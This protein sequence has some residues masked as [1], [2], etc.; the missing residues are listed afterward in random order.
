MFLRRLVIAPFI[1]VLLI[2]PP[3]A[4]AATL[5]SSWLHQPAHHPIHRGPQVLRPGVPP[6]SPVGY[7]PCDL[8]NAYRLSGSG[9]DGTGVTIAI[10]D[11][12]AQPN[13]ATDLQA[14]DA[15]V[16]L[17]DPTLN[18]IP[19]GNPP[20]GPA[21]WQDEITLD[22]EW[23][24]AMAPRATIDLVEAHSDMLVEPNPPHAGLL[25]AV[26]FVSH[27]LNPDVLSM[28]FGNPETSLFANASDELNVDSQL[29]PATNGAGHPM[30]YTASTG[31]SGFGANWPAVSTSV[32]GV[33][34]T[35][36]SLAAFGYA[37]DPGSHLACSPTLTPGV[38]SANETVWG[39]KL[40]SGV[41]CGT[42]GGPS[43]F[44]SKP[45]W[46][47]MAPTTTRS[48]PDIAALADSFTGVA[49]FENGSWNSFRTGGT[50]L[51]APIWAGLTA[52]LDQGRHN[53]SLANLNQDRRALWVYSTTS[54]DFNDI[55]TGSAPS[56][57][58]CGPNNACMA[59]PGYDQVT[60]R[61]STLF[62][63]LEADMAAT[64]PLPP[65]GNLSSMPPV[66]IMDTRDGTGGVPAAP[67][68]PFQTIQL[69]IPQVPNGTAAVV[70]N[71]T[72]ADTTSDGF[73]L[74]YPNGQPQPNASTLNYRTGEITSVLA[75]VQIGN[76]TLNVF[77][78]SSGPAD[79]IIDL[80]GF[81]SASPTGTTGLFR[82]LDSPIR[83]LDTRSSL[84]GHN[85]PLQGGEISPLQVAGNPGIP[86]SPAI[87]LNAS[88]I[89]LNLTGVTPNQ[90]TFLA[91]YPAR[92]DGT[93][94]PH[95]NFSNLNLPPGGIKPNRVIVQIGGS[96]KIC[97]FNLIGTVDVVIDLSGWFSGGGIGDTTGLLFTAWTPTR[98]YDSRFV[99][100]LGPGALQCPGT[101]FVLP[102][103]P[104]VSAVSFNLTGLNSNAGTFLESFPTNHGP[105]PPGTSDVNLMAGEI[106]PNLTITKVDAGTQ[107]I[108]ICNFNVFADFIVDV[109][110]VYRS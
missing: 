110:G 80:E 65:E 9:L 85:G 87:P 92:I 69:A 44:V 50:S 72:V 76:G 67:M 13:I 2:A 28:S 24:H 64:G 3:P 88:A 32:I 62:P 20:V 105:S 43:A 42:G 74:V 60:G 68:Q 102:I 79:V 98:L 21:A 95:G 103:P 99:A 59:G 104:A 66:R 75:Q 57:S 61:G 96:G 91:V 78:H 16:G 17:P 41:L 97:I 23:A 70:V 33:G 38:T 71:V 82:P 40:C 15:A 86:S 58:G 10:V 29:F 63:T 107:S 106:R 11:A 73:V 6:G 19:L 45:G 8:A 25:D 14:F 94:G 52:L 27:T 31:D 7:I 39:N 47:S 34:G 81:Y 77:L 101:N 53:H 109:G 84:G 22:V 36:L 18:V 48:S 108:S 89:V 83:A 51:S 46:Q 5:S 55:I 56:T 26:F 4:S 49:T 1:A 35:S 30:T 100:P 90:F 37:S 12:F 54:A 93:C